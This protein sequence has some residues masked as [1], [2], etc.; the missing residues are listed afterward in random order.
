[1]IVN[2]YDSREGTYR[3]VDTNADPDPRFS[4][5]GSHTLNEFVLSE[6]LGQRC[7]FI[8]ICDEV[9]CLGKKYQLRPSLRSLC[10]DPR[11]SL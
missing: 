10:D 11:D 7:Y 1:M 6:R 2:G 4:R 9:G 3:L 8:R 5:L